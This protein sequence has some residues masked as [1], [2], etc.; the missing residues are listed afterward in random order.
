MLCQ[1]AI[2]QH[3]KVAVSKHTAMSACRLE[4]CTKRV[5]TIVCLQFSTA[6]EDVLY[7]RA[8]AVAVRAAYGLGSLAQ[9]P[10]HALRYHNSDL[11][12]T[13]TAVYC[14]LSMYTGAYNVK[15]SSHNSCWRCNSNCQWPASLS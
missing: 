7:T 4:V 15:R 10:A 1:H 11:T 2:T 3:V 9:Y 6:Y 12:V 5:I 8:L 14:L 13:A